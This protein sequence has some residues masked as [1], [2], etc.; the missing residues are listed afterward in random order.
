[1]SYQYH[2]NIISYHVISISII[3]YD[4]KQIYLYVCDSAGMD[5]VSSPRGREVEIGAFPGASH[6]FQWPTEN[7]AVPKVF[8]KRYPRYLQ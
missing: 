7:G 5:Q 3:S 4:Y 8:L 6:I 2:I 1:M